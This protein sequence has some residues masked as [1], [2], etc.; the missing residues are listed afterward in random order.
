M[1]LHPSEYWFCPVPFSRV[2]CAVSNEA[3]V[4]A[5]RFSV[6]FFIAK[7]QA[8]VVGCRRGR[9]V[10]PRADPEGKMKLI[11]HPC[12]QDGVSGRRCGRGAVERARVT[13]RIVPDGLPSLRGEVGEW[14]SPGGGHSEPVEPDPSLTRALPG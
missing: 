12:E 6:S 7:P 9:G 1:S 13:G 8:R 5:S 3:T 14:C 2:R 4:N 11:I 10:S